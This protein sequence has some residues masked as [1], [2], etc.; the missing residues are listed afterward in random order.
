M[1]ATSL[2]GIL[3]RGSESGVHDS[4]VGMILVAT[5]AWG[6]SLAGC[7][8]G[9]AER[10]DIPALLDLHRKILESLGGR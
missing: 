5:I 7:Q 10:E 3:T 1:K 8:M 4:F 6:L 9:R 2:G